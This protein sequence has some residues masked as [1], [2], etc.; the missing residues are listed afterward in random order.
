MRCHG[1]RRAGS[2]AL[3][4]CWLAAGRVDGFWEWKLKA[5]DT[6]AAALVVREA[7][8]EIS[9]FRGRPFDPFAEQCLA[10]NGRIH[11]EM[12]EVVGSLV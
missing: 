7:G 11:G 3:D 12:L 1:I 10:S 8:G 2:A 5:W 6:A 9:D 4:L